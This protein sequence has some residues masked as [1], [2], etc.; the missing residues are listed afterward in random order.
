[1]VRLN[2]SSIVP[3]T[4]ITVDKERK[5]LNISR[6]FFGRQTRRWSL[7]SFHPLPFLSDSRCDA[8]QAQCTHKR[9][10]E[11]VQNCATRELCHGVFW[12]QMES[13]LHHNTSKRILSSRSGLHRYALRESAVPFNGSHDVRIPVSVA[14]QSCADCYRHRV[15]HRA[16]QWVEMSCM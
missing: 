14:R 16:S 8:D 6:L 4:C 12:V 10:N 2:Q 7:D 13:G 1:M 5:S 11:E 3:S 9:K 15:P